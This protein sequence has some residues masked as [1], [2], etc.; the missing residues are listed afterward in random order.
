[1]CCATTSGRMIAVD[2]VTMRHVRADRPVMVHGSGEGRGLERQD[3]YPLDGRLR[4]VDHAL[5]LE[6]GLRRGE[7]GDGNAERRA[8]YVV[9]AGVVAELH[10]AGL[11]AVLAANP[12]LQIGAV[13]PCP[14]HLHLLPVADPLLV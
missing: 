14:A 6:R 1:M 12:D 9:H 3:S 4:P 13:A 5:L 8:R 11:A 10:R 7:P 2:S